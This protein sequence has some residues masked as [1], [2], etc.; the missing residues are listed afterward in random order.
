MLYKNIIDMH[1]HSDNSFDG[2]H[3]VVLLCEEAINKGAKGIAIT[4]HCD[5]DSKTM[6]FRALTTNQFVETFQAKA[7]FAGSL[8]VMQGIELGQ[9]IYNKELSESILNSFKYDFV[10]GSIHNLYETEDFYFLDYKLYD[11]YDL[12]QKYFE[13]ELELA[14]WGN[15]DTLA[16]LTYPLRYIVAREGIRVDLSKYYDLIDAIFEELIKNDKAL[17]I[18]TSGLFLEMAETLP[19]KDLI[20]RFKDLGGKFVTIGS[21]SH[22]ADRVCNGIEKGMELAK[23]C[24]FD[25]IT[26]FEKRVPVEI[27]IV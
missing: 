13:A 26:I 12:L 2:N 21:D 18:N 14:Q 24:G 10:L 17:E 19:G 25:N 8:V 22:S 23:E 6:D 3:S 11:I 20:K 4:D 7:N 1:T 15:F 16:H 9:P 5:I 27:P